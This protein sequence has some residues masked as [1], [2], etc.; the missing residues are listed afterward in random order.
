M[1]FLGDFIAIN[2]MLL[3]ESSRRKPLSCCGYIDTPV[4]N[5][6]FRVTLYGAD[7]LPIVEDPAL[8]SRAP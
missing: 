8:G 5:A 6:S 7:T 2:K 3:D 1:R 4:G